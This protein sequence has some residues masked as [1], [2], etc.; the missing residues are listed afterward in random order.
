M[1]GSP[2]FR[3]ADLPQ[4]ACS[5]EGV[6]FDPRA[7]LWRF[8]SGLQDLNIDV[9]EIERLAPNLIG[10]FRRLA[11]WYVENRSTSLANGIY[12]RLLHF[13]RSQPGGRLAGSITAQQILTYRSGL[14][15]DQ[16]WYLTALAG[17]LRRWAAFELPGMGSDAPRLLKQLRLEGNRK[18]EAVR[19]ACPISGPLSDIEFTGLVSALNSAFRDGILTRERFILASLCITLGLRPVQ[20][21]ALKTLDLLPQGGEGPVS[22]RV[23]RAKQPQLGNRIVFKE[24]PLA[25]ALAQ[26]LRVHVVDVESRLIGHSCP[27]GYPMFPASALN[28]TDWSPGLECHLTPNNIYYRVRSAL[29][30]VEVHSERTGLPLRLNPTRLRRTL[31]T[32]AAAEGHGEM[33]IAEMLDHSDLQNVGVYAE[34]RPDIIDR[35]NEAMASALAPYAR[36]FMGRIEED[37]LA[38]EA[39][40]GSIRDPRFGLAGP[41]G[42]CG[43]S[44]VCRLTAPAGCY[45]CTSFRAWRDG[46]HREVLQ[47][48][49]DERDRLKG[50]S[51]DR[52]AAVND[53][54]ILAVAQVVQLC[55]ETSNG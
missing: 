21:A 47:H 55:A 7:D 24:R 19:T 34:A 14:S 44:N 48:L 27:S 2:K 53:R 23:P 22:L 37:G 28:K 25:P 12:Q 39:P 5:A 41:L 49:V 17:A 54:T 36:A 51:S 15:P 29:E 50:I 43:S 1:S 45:T 18:G 30:G 6:E 10:S 3:Q 9:G 11:L 20:L 52:I 32:R 31:G 13:L 33:V 4:V 46:P 38:G 26:Q 16:C 8:R 42:G 35:L 40:G